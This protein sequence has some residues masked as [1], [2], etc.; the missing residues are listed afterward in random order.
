[1][2]TQTQTE[3]KTQTQTGDGDTDTDTDIQTTHTH[4]HTHT[5]THRHRH[6]HRHRYLP[7][8]GHSDPH[9][10]THQP[11]H[12]SKGLTLP[13]IS[14]GRRDQHLVRSS[15]LL[16]CHTST[17]LPSSTSFCFRRERRRERLWSVCWRVAGAHLKKK[18]KKK[19]GCQLRVKE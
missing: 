7:R 11:T 1:M 9:P 15:L 12:S 10:V 8:H 18:R 17:A 3:M 19:N 6:R 16:A 2:K 4:L 13:A 14:G 5:H